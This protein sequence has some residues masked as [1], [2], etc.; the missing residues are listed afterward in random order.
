MQGLDEHK[1]NVLQDNTSNVPKH[2]YITL[3]CKSFW[4]INKIE[5]GTLVNINIMNLN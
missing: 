1:T 2:E 3:T 4:V 5:K